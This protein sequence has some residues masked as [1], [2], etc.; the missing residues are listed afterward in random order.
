MGIL[1]CGLNG[2][3]KS[4]LGKVLADR[5]G[6]EFIDNEDLYFPKT[7]AGYTFS[8]PRSKEEAIRL[9]EEK[10]KGNSRFVFAA[11]K[12]DYG[13]KLA[14]SLNYIVLIEVPKEIRNRRVRERSFEKFGERILPGG[15]LYEKETA[16]FSLTDSRPE[17]YTEKWLE[18]V[19]CP[20]IRVDGTLPVQQNADYLVSVLAQT[21]KEMVE[22]RKFTDFP[23]GTLY[24]LLADA[25]S[26]DERN[27]QIWDA[28]WKETDDFFYD[29]PEIADQYSLVTCLDGKPIG[30]VTWDPRHRPEYVEIGYNGIREQYKGRGYGRLQL[31]EALR[32]IKQ[33]EGLKRIIVGTNSNLVAPR[34]YESVGFVLADRKQ[35]HTESEY[36]GDYLRYE[37]IL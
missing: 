28:D 32:R 24:E 7:D 15:D 6:Y 31:E 30:F 25:W 18:T 21:D 3:G 20:V 35:N 16:W 4:T 29:N 22:F 23:R 36:T 8:A 26:F 19:N 2:S 9:L 10:I 14:A 11:V 12:G 5:I 37:I 33:Y 27:R 1:I 13:D 17:D 34:N